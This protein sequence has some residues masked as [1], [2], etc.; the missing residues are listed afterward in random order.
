VLRFAA[1]FEPLRQILDGVRAILYFSAAGDAGLTR[2]VVM[3]GLGLVLW[4]VL[5]VAVTTWYD[6]KG[7]YRLQPDLMAY[8]NRSV[9]AYPREDHEP[10]SPTVSQSDQ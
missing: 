3:T 10:V 5:G 9:R 2:G 1:N 7:L 8:V 4:V 6:R